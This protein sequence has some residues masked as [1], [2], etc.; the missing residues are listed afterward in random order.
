MIHLKSIYGCYT[1][2]LYSCLAY[3]RIVNIPSWEVWTQIL[4]TQ[5]YCKQNMHTLH[6]H[7][8]ILL[9]WFLCYSLIMLFT[10]GDPDYLLRSSWHSW[11]A[12]RITA[13]WI[14]LGLVATA[15]NCWFVTEQPRSSLMPYYAYVRFMAMILRP[16][17]WRLVSLSEA[18]MCIN[19]MRNLTS[20]HCSQ[21]IYQLI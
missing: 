10:F 15:R 20:A 8:Y 9:K 2:H 19:W 4:N 1:S 12:P 6:V 3:G 14:L 18:Y 5:Q 11:P 16:L 13:R 21:N 17:P 7:A